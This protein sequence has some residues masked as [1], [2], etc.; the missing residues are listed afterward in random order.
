MESRELIFKELNIPTKN[1]LILSSNW[2]VKE[3][4]S[5]LLIEAFNKI[6]ESTSNNVSLVMVGGHKSDQF[7]KEAINSGAIVFGKRVSHDKLIQLYQS[8][9]VLVRAFNEPNVVRFA[10]MGNTILESVACGTPVISNNLIHFHGNKDERRKIGILMGSGKKL[11]QKIL[12]ILN[13]KNNYQ[14]CRYIA[15]KYFD[16][17]KSTNEYFSSIKELLNKYYK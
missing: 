16:H 9:D 15:E 5:D 2:Y 13:N 11:A 1:K 12:H 4:G 10:G 8:A 17:E 7:Y 14:E 6:K 3:Y